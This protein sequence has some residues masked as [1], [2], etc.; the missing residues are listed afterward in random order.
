[1]K[2]TW[3]IT[4][5]AALLFFPLFVFRSVAWFDFWWWISVN[6]A[7]LLCA[8]AVLDETWRKDIA[9]DIRERLIW[10]IGMGVLSAAV[11]YG[12]FY[13]GNIISRWLFFFAGTGIDGVYAFKTDASAFRIGL[14]MLCLIGP[15]EELFWRGFLQRRLQGGYGQWRGFLLA[16]M[17]YTLI[18]IG[19]GNVMLVLA[20]GVCGLFWGFLYLR[21][22]SMLLNA[23][24]HTL[25]DVAIFLVLPVV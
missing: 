9:I 13:A 25:W 7:L 5:L 2:L 6:I 22:R 12:V 11:L 23:I 21:F 14:L 8:A 1:M 10:K 19:S 24:S 20:A 15:G 17:I 16:T 18:H 3:S 4:A